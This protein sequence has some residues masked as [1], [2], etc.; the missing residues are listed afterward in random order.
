M[1]NTKNVS[2]ANRFFPK[3][4]EKNI[5]SM[6]PHFKC[7]LLCHGSWQSGEICFHTRII[8][9][10]LDGKFSNTRTAA[11]FPLK[12][13]NQTIRVPEGPRNGKDSRMRLINKLLLFRI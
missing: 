4:R 3:I 10:G 5:F 7:A 1:G 2:I 6:E 9:F 13:P 12:S 11:I 8:W